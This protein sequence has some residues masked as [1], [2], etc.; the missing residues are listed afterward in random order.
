MK[1]AI[2]AVM[3]VMSSVVC[4]AQSDQ[5]DIENVQVVFRNVKKEFVSEYMKIDHDISHTSFWNLYDEY[6]R[7]RSKIMGSRYG[8]IKKYIDHYW[9]LDNMT[10]STIVKELMRNSEQT[11]RL[12][13]HYFRKFEKEIGGLQAATLF[14]I[15]LYFQTSVQSS[16]QS[17]IPLIGE[18][19]K[20]QESQ[21]GSNIQR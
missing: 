11:D 14:Q 19:Q 9:N 6:E 16:I 8:L 18:L 12:N 21:L 10:A 4:F 3:I 7:K 20:I 13:K 1:R 15:E 5:A 17:Q 2:S